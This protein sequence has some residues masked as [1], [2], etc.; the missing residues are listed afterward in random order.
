MITAE[1]SAPVQ[2]VSLS[3]RFARLRKPMSRLAAACF[4]ALLVFSTS[5]ADPVGTLV[6]EVV[7][8]LL[9][10]VGV[11]GRVW[12]AIYIAGRKNSE[13]CQDGPYSL[14]RNPLYLFSFIALVGIAL[15][16]RLGTVA[17]VLTPLFW[18]Y[19]HFVIRSEESKLREMFGEA[20]EAYR[21]E[22]PRIIPR[23]RGYWSRAD[24]VTN[25]RILARNLLEVAW[26]LVLLAMLEVVEHGRGI[27]G[28]EYRLPTLVSFPF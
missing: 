1:A 25:P 13:L 12:C 15:A 28:E 7:G 14:C 19:H 5:V 23:F 11:L 6:I 8:I 26:F 3:T 4:L 22:V 18:L 24:L 27:D 2:A 10:A 9:L 20:F 16:A 17:V 21:R